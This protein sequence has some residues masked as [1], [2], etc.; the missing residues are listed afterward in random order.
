MDLALV[1]RMRFRVVGAML[2]A[3]RPLAVSR[4]DAAGKSDPKRMWSS[5][6]RAR[7]LGR[8]YWFQAWAVSK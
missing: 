6:M 7:R 5:G 3:V 1:A 2:A 4:G 8:V